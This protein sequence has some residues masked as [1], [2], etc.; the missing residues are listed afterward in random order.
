[1]YRYVYYVT[2]AERYYT[3][4]KR[5]ATIIYFP[6][7]TVDTTGLIFFS[8]SLDD[9]IEENQ[10]INKNPWAACPLCWIKYLKVCTFWFLRSRCSMNQL[11][12][13]KS[14]CPC[15]DD[16]DGVFAATVFVRRCIYARK[17]VHGA[18]TH[19]GNDGDE[20]VF[21][22]FL[23]PHDAHKNPRR[24]GKRDFPGARKTNNNTHRSAWTQSNEGFFL[25]KLLLLFGGSERNV[26]S[27]NNFTY[28]K[29]LGSQ[30]FTSA[31]WKII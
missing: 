16:D 29:T 30:Y 8:S 3:V 23:S 28:N 6:Q 27:I 26:N 22:I 24:R 5:Y 2:S 1:M 19:R 13:R 12:S 9:D 17:I 4:R 31:D 15:Q 25:N 21:L 11:C 10:K 18:R 7:T 14:V 20:L